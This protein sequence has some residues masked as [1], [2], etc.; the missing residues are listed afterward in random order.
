MVGGGF[1]TW[2]WTGCCLSSKKREKRIVVENWENLEKC[3]TIKLLSKDEGFTQWTFLV[4]GKVLETSGHVKFLLHFLG[5]KSK[6]NS[7]GTWAVSD[8]QSRLKSVT[9]LNALSTYLGCKLDFGVTSI[10]SSWCLAL[11]RMQV[12]S[13]KSLFMLTLLNDVRYY[14]YLCLHCLLKILQT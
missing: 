1:P 10:T 11:A 2:G 7:R 12:V 3:L 13:T 9:F 6:I 5:Q 4:N 14:K 8:Y